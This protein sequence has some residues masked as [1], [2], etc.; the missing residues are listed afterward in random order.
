[1]HHNLARFIVIDLS[2]L[3]GVGWRTRIAP[4]LVAIDILSDRHISVVATRGNNVTGCTDFGHGISTDLSCGGHAT[5][6]SD[7]V[8]CSHLVQMNYL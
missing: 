5:L 8:C 3:T 7:E 2:V 4:S 6:R 1:M